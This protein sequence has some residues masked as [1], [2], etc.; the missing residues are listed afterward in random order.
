MNNLTIT[1]AD[2]FYGTLPAA[3]MD[4]GFCGLAITAVI[5]I[6]L[7]AYGLYYEKALAMVLAFI[8]IIPFSIIGTYVT[9]GLPD[10]HN[11]RFIEC[12]TVGA[13]TMF[14]NQAYDGVAEQCRRTTDLTKPWSEW[15]LKKIITPGDFK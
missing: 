13:R 14:N 8:L 1:L 4:L 15:K 11:A 3:R 12:E 7:M 9:F 5:P 10:A 2:Y 6:C